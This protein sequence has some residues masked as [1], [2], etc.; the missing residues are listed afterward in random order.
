MIRHFY[1]LEEVEG[2][3]RRYTQVIGA[4]HWESMDLVR[5]VVLLHLRAG[6]IEECT[7]W[8]GPCPRGDGCSQTGLHTMHAVRPPSVELP[9]VNLVEG[10]RITVPTLALCA[11]AQS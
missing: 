5:Y 9:T 1:Y 10:V 7:F 4:E 2:N 6:W 8:M 11:L 3:A